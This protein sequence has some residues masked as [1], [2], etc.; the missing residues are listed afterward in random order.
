MA[1]T[2]PGSGAAGDVGSRAGV[3]RAGGPASVVPYA[4]RDEVVVLVK[5]AE[6]AAARA[7]KAATLEAAAAVAAEI[8][9]IAETLTGKCPDMSDDADMANMSL[10]ATHV[11]ALDGLRRRRPAAFAVFAAAGQ[12]LYAHPPT[13][14]DT[15]GYY[16][17]LGA[18]LLAQV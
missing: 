14:H 9:E 15:L 2:A 16:K 11:A 8:N 17:R 10:D 12:D 1:A 3:A 6:L 13:M 18:K 7:A 5:Q 4:T